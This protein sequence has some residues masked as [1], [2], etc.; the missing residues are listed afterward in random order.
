MKKL[1]FLLLLFTACKSKSANTI[2]ISVNQ[3]TVQ[4]KGIPATELYGLESDTISQRAWQS[5]FPVF[6]LP[7][8]TDLR[9]YQSPVAGRY[10][11]SGDVILFTP[12]T[13]FAKD[14]TY[15]ARY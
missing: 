5:L 13:A 7:A 9:N 12:D 11:L 14:S 4:V 6:K 2:T 10:S 15:F 1:A 8:D 3:K